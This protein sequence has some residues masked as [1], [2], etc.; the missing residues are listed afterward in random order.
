[1]AAAVRRNRPHFHTGLLVVRAR[2]AR[3]RHKSCSRFITELHFENETQPVLQ[4]P[5]GACP[6]GIVSLNKKLRHPS[7]L[8]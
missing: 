8:A 5:A 3:H 7:I 1:M 4:L 6:H 2:S